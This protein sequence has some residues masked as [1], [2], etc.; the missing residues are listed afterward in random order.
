MLAHS[1][2]FDNAHLV[3]K[4]ANIA[5]LKASCDYDAAKIQ[6]EVYGSWGTAVSGSFFSHVWDKTRVIVAYWDGAP[7]LLA[8]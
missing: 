5:N 3:N 2:L 6:S 8:K 7:R 4:D 1:T